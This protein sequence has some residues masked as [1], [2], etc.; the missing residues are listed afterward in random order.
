MEEKTESA[1]LK[2]TTQISE[3]FAIINYVDGTTSLWYAGSPVKHGL[4]D[5]E[6][7]LLLKKALLAKFVSDYLRGSAKK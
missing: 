4:K 5:K 6:A 1:L 2:V 3:K 7:A